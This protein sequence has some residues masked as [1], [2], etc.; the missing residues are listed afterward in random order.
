[1]RLVI[2][3]SALLSLAR[4]TLGSWTANC[5]ATSSVPCRIDGATTCT[6]NDLQPTSSTNLGAEDENTYACYTLVYTAGGRHWLIRGQADMSC[7]SHCSAMKIS[8][9]NTLNYY[10]CY[11][12]RLGNNENTN[13]ITL[14]GQSYTCEVASSTT[15][16]TTPG[17]TSWVLG[18]TWQ[19]A[20]IA[21]CTA[22]T[23][24]GLGIVVIALIVLLCYLC[25]RARDP[26]GAGKLHLDETRTDIIQIKQPDGPTADVQV[27]R[28]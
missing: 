14:T 9:G 8:Y 21:I 19:S 22:I 17:T 20:T 18:G 10:A 16:S 25:L 27:R 24:L 11:N 1:M 28:N 23:A 2:L 5:Y 13:S 3:V 12:Y 15:A 26:S 6:S 7:P 4:S